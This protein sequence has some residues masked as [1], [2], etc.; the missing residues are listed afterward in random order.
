VRSQRN[1]IYERSGRLYIRY[2]DSQ[3]RIRREAVTWKKLR[4][5]EIKVDPSVKLQQPGR[6]LAAKLL[7]ARRGACDKG[8]KIAALHTRR[9]TFGELADTALLHCKAH[10]RGYA[11]YKSRI[12]KLKEKFG[13]HSADSL[14]STD[15]TV[16]FDSH[17][18]WSPATRNRY[19]AALSLIYKLARK[20]NKALPNPARDIDH[21]KE[22]RGR[23]R[24]LN[25]RL[26]LPTD[27]E[28]LQS[29]KDEESRLRAVIAEN[30]PWHLDEFVIAL[31]CG[32]RPSEMY[33]LTWDSV[34]L[35]RKQIFVQGTKTGHDRYVPLNGEALAAFKRL[36]IRPVRKARVFLAKDGAALIGNRHWFPSAVTEAGLAGDFTF[37][38][39]RHTFATRLVE[40]GV[41]IKTVQELMGHQTI[42]MTARYAHSS[43]KRRAAAVARLLTHDFSGTDTSTDTV[44]Q[45]PEP[46]TEQI[47]SLQ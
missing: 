19:R 15:V 27:L 11:T 46:R 10:N 40:S 2:S 41:D 38:C 17:S 21:H 9:V 39:L 43:D 28:Y 42:G 7:N 31:N 23:Y 8:E 32:L 18:A 12:G 34:D 29:R 45:S 37:Y 47:V 33:A 16:W 5:A 22:S 36:Y 24:F 3:H 14:S 35:V 26:P 25:D 30:S 4:D 44:S 13:C 20:A 6:E 1:P